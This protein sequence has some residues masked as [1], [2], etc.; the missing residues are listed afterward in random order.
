MNGYK[1]KSKKTSE[2]KVRRK[3]SGH[4]KPIT[5]IKL[6][7]FKSFKDECQIT[8]K[9][10]TLLAGSN[11]SGKSSIFQ[12][13]LMMKQ[14]LNEVYDPGALQLNGANV[15]FTHVEQL[16]TKNS[17]TKEFYV[18]IGNGSHNTVKMTYEKKGQS[19]SGL[20]IKS[21]TI[22][23]EGKE[24]TVEPD[25][26]LDEETLNIILQELPGFFGDIMKSEPNYYPKIGR[27]RCFLEFS[28]FDEDTKSAFVS[29]SFV[30]LM[31][32]SIRE[33]I[34]LPGL[35]GNPERNY[36]LTAID[37]EKMSFSGTFEKYVASIIA[38]WIDTNN[39]KNLIK[40]KGYL[41]QLSLANNIETKYISDT[42]ISLHVSRFNKGNKDD[43]VSIAD[44]GLGVSQT[45]PIL[46][47]LL[48]A[49]RGQMVYIEQPEIHLHPR[50]QYELATIFADAIKRGIILVI[51]THSAVLLRGIQTA[52]VNEKIE[53]DQVALHWFSCNQNTGY[54]Y[55]NSAN[56]DENGAFGDWP[57]DFDDTTLLA[58]SNYL[59]AVEKR[60]FDV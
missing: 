23:D 26:E 40:L 55:V 48:M 13:I 38:N 8:I 22:K 10:L 19:K 4:D 29:R 18:E 53:K 17:D 25:C 39:T 2:T 1:K 32:S 7:G 42:E 49:K 60:L 3:L 43:L 12:P 20:D 11:S 24:F 52:V 47:A 33:I 45:L 31:Q 46:V 59:D 51:E 28:I 14:T 44:V 34:H 56:L 27:N 35:R 9:P 6:R 50:A 58:E 30:G 41:K 57:E 15:K 37:F 16:I 5:S 54:S 21:M 36:P